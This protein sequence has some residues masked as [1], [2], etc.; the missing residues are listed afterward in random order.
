MS[1]KPIPDHG[2]TTI[3]VEM[4][5]DGVFAIAMTLLVLDIKVPVLEH[6][7]AHELPDRL[8]ELWPKYLGYVISFIMLGVYWVGH[9][10]QF[11]A[12]RRT[13]R[14]LLW[15]N[16]L[17]LMAIGFLP[18]STAL[19]TAYFDQQVPVII[20]GANLVVIGLL[21]YWHWWHATDHHHLVDADLDPEFIK[22]AARRVLRGVLILIVAIG[23]SFISIAATLIIYLVLPVTYILPGSVDRFWQRRA[24]HPSPGE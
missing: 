3:R 13:D 24:K 18:F 8:V 14:P 23:M 6:S 1:R 2:L 11:H 16:V 10:N 22:I 9:H 12:I 4:L 19:L 7:M 20:Y 21:L 17:F 5:T 15:I